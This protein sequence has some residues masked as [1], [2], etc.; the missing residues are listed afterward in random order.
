M[1]LH[2]PNIVAAFLAA[3]RSNDAR[4]LASC[5]SAN[6]AVHD[7]ARSHKGHAAIQQ[8]KEEADAKYSYTS[9]SLMS[10]TD[11]AMVTVRSRVTGS[12]PGSPVELSQVFTIADEQI[13]SLEIR[14]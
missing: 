5:F 6:G 1:E 12:F 3:E 7:E 10:T 13:V 2:I 8:W 14:A 11:G 4:E 9:E